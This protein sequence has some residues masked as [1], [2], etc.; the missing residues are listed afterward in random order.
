VAKPQ[1]V[2]RAATWEDPVLVASGTAV[3]LYEY[4]LAGSVV[5]KVTPVIPTVDVHSAAA[6]ALMLAGVMTTG[7]DWDWLCGMSDETVEV[8]V[9]VVEPSVQY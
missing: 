4:P 5:A 2:E 8:L 1:V 7:A 9:G 3:N 6:L